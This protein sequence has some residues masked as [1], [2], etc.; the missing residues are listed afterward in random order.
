MRYL[1]FAFFLCTVLTQS[2]KSDATKPSGAAAAATSETDTVLYHD[3]V[4][5][6]ATVDPSTGNIDLSKS[7]TDVKRYTSPYQASGC[8]LVSNDLFKQVFG[9]SVDGNVTV[10]SIPDKGHCIWVW[11][12]PNWME[13]ENAN[14]K[15]GA[16]YQ[17]FKNTMSARVINFQIVDAAQKQ[18]QMIL[19]TQAKSYTEK[20]DGVADEAIWS[21]TEN[22]LAARKGHLLTYLTVEVGNSAENLAK[23]KQI[24]AGGYKL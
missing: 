18:F 1:F 21:A 14:E 6:K 4:G 17:E 16:T 22:T 12:K 23:A 11:K 20:V 15:K 7:T 19:Q 13:I 9:V 5:Q 8:N 2:C 10:N 24:L 3:I